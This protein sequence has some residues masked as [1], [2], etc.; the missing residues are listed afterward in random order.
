MANVNARQPG[1]VG[2]LDAITDGRAPNDLQASIQGVFDLREHVFLAKRERYI[3]NAV[4]V[5]AG[6][7]G[8]FS[9]ASTPTFVVPP[10]EA[11]WIYAYTV[12]GVPGSAQQMALQCHVQMPVA[13]GNQA[14]PIGPLVAAVN[15]TN[16][17]QTAAYA[18]RQLWVPPGTILGF[19]CNSN[20]TAAAVNITGIV[21]YIRAR[22]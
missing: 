6:S 5:A 22:L 15:T 21:D 12:Q 18:D 14:F 13:G 4:S 8:H 9:F 10:G 17:N 2:L 11:W 16:P 19:T 20:T 1:L 7:T 3:S